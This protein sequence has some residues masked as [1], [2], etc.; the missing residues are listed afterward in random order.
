MSLTS[1]LIEA[2]INSNDN[3][4][5][6]SRKNLLESRKLNIYQDPHHTSNERTTY[7]VVDIPKTGKRYYYMS[8]VNGELTFHGTLE[9]VAKEMGWSPYALQRRFIEYGG[10][11]FSGYDYLHYDSYTDLLK[12]DTYA[13]DYPHMFT[14]YKSDKSN[15]DYIFNAL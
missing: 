5:S 7:L 14:S 8:F 4:T 13:L 9:E 15:I 10:G 2:A 12:I 6:L 3:T 1:K 11:Y